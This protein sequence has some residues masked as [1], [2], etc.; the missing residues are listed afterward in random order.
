MGAVLM[1]PANAARFR[2]YVLDRVSG[3]QGVSADAV[4]ADCPACRTRG[5]LAIVFAGNRPEADLLCLDGCA[6]AAVRDALRRRRSS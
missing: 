4:T 5:C 3:A 1:L 6:E 2:D